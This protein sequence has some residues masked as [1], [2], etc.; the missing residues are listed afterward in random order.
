MM[1]C[2]SAEELYTGR[3]RVSP[4][5]TPPTR[6]PSDATPDRNPNPRN[7]GLYAQFIRSRVSRIMPLDDTKAKRKRAKKITPANSLHLMMGMIIDLHKSVD[8][9]R[10]ELRDAWTDIED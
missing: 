4:R 2:R 9:L 10:H 6:Q 3:H 8:A 7:E 1:G 5:A